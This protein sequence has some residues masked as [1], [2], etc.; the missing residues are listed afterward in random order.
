MTVLVQA[1]PARGQQSVLDQAQTERGNRHLSLCR[2]RCS[3][4]CSGSTVK[5]DRGPSLF[6]LGPSPEIGTVL[7]QAQPK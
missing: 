4:P 6:R 5:V 3:C 7:V 2:L 1:Q